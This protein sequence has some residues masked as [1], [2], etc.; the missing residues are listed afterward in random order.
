MSTPKLRTNLMTE[1]EDLELG[2]CIFH[3]TGVGCT[4]SYEMGTLFKNNYNV[5]ETDTEGL[6]PVFEEVAGHS[7]TYHANKLQ[8]NQYALH[9]TV[10]MKKI[11]KL[12]QS[13]SDINLI[14][15]I[16]K[17]LNIFDYTSFQRRFKDKLSSFSL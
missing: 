11:Q 7:A 14:S 9:A 15:V 2:R 10:M 3:H 4:K 1:H 13:G 12:R 5:E 17:L 16:Y 6:K 8:E